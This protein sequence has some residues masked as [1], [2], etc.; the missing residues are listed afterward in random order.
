MLTLYRRHAKS[1]GKTEPTHYPSTAKERSADTCL[2]RINVHG[3]LE[4]HA[5]RIRHYSLETSDWIE[6]HDNANRMM[7]SGRLPGSNSAI[8]AESSV[9]VKFAVETYLK[10]R[11][12]KL[13]DS[14]MVTY[15]IFLNQRLL[16][17]CD[18]N[19]IVYLKQLES[20]QVVE[21]FELSWRNLKNGEPLD[22]GMHNN[23]IQ[24]LRTFLN[25]CVEK[26]EWITKN[27][28][29]RLEK[30]SSDD[31]DDD[32][33]KVG[34]ELDEYERNLK[35]LQTYPRTLD[36]KRLTAFVRLMRETGM[37]ISDATKF[38]KSELIRNARDTTWLARFVQKKTGKRCTVPV[39][40]D[41]VEMLRE[42]PFLLDD[43]GYW[44]QQSLDVAEPDTKWRK[45]INKLF[46]DT[47]TLFGK[48]FAHHA[49]PH[50]LRHT[51]A[52]QWLNAGVDI[53]D[54]SKWLGHRNLMVTIRSYSHDN[55]ETIERREDASIQALR[56]I[57]QKT[58]AIS[59][60]VI[61]IRSR[62]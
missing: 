6:A 2:C 45:Q 25:Y 38:R 42:L 1:C 53:R 12:E 41:V 40:S 35:A 61:S 22:D 14:T 20:F 15:G 52:I 46:A 31:P 26:Q 3:Y 54:V 16:P 13:H 29:K 47:E 4:H 33:E 56:K 27:V 51:A 55:K 19:K 17:W 48:K 10:A 34:F 11:T 43:G 62:A 23:T 30:K 18:E 37:R 36:T 59:D 21:A 32:S 44:F 49:T 58:A 57:K 7:K 9:T 24:A 39:D 28:A 5:G 8:G 50:T 60:K